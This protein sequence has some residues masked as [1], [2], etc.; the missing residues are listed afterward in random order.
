VYRIS[1]IIWF[2]VLS[3]LFSFGCGAVE[4]VENP[5]ALK[6]EL[7]LVDSIVDN[8]IDQEFMI[9]YPVDICFGPSGEILVLDQIAA[10]VYAFDSDGVFLEQFG[11]IGEGPGEMGNPM[12]IEVVE[13]YIMIR[14]AVKHGYLLFDSSYELVEEVSHWPSASPTDMQYC[15]DNS[16]VARSTSLENADDGLFIGRNISRYTLGAKEPSR[17]YFSE[18]SPVDASDPSSILRMGTESLVFTSDLSGRIYVTEITGE[19]YLVTVY[20]PHGDTLYTITRDCDPVQKSQAEL[21]EEITSMEAEMRLMGVEGVGD[22]VPYPLKSMIIGLGTDADMNLWVQRGTE[23]QQTLDVYNTQAGGELICTVV[24]P[25][26]G[27]DWSIRVSSQGIIAWQT[28][29]PDGYFTIYTLKLIQSA[30]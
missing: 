17:M 16:F 15:G 6:Y 22:W 14:D 11:G 20:G 27:H 18:L 7:C 1:C 4:E 3:V 24:L 19:E 30:E 13:G 23:A 2:S 12:S 10:A 28:D 26:P 29:P 21:D 25:R 8:S 5:S 9:G